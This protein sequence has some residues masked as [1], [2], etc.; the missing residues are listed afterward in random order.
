MFYIE[1]GGNLFV[2]FFCNGYVMVMSFCM[3][4]CVCVGV[5]FWFGS[6]LKIGRYLS[7]G[8]FLEI[9][10]GYLFVEGIFREEIL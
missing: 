10:L 4:F 3:I 1:L 6:F 2:F 8:R 9:F 5:F 7:F